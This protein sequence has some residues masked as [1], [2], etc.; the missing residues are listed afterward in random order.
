[1]ESEDK[2]PHRLQ[3]LRREEPLQHGTGKEENRLVLS[4]HGSS[5]SGPLR[6]LEGNHG[7]SILTEGPPRKVRNKIE[8]FRVWRSDWKL[9]RDLHR[10]E[11]GSSP[12][13]TPRTPYD[14]LTD[15]DLEGNN[16][17]DDP[18]ID[19]PTPTTNPASPST[20]LEAAADCAWLA[21]STQS[22]EEL[23]KELVERFA[24][25]DT[26]AP[27]PEP[28]VSD[29]QVAPAGEGEAH[30]A[31][32]AGPRR[33]WLAPDYDEEADGEGDSEETEHEEEDYGPGFHPCCGF[34]TP[35]QSPSHNE[36]P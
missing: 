3:D 14:P 30:P 7:A 28:A 2:T 33:T 11:Y 34:F 4:S 35:P 6:G 25:G 12:P 10:W 24:G 5:S 31:G 21:Q 27:P 18:D 13:T 9:D 23:E 16:S 26:T 32:A 29:Q 19:A 17:N 36:S 20:V 15:S 8:K 22:E 1:M